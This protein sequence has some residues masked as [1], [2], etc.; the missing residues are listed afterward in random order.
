MLKAFGIWL[1]SLCVA[2]SAYA[3]EE[4]SGALHATL[5]GKVVKKDFSAPRVVEHP[6]FGWFIEL[7]SPSQT[8]VAELFE[9]LSPHEKAI[10]DDLDLKCIRIRT[11]NT[12]LRDWVREQY[13]H[14][15][16]VDG[17]IS[18]PDL[19][20]RELRAF[21]FT[22]EIEPE[23]VPKGEDIFASEFQEDWNK[24]HE[25]SYLEPRTPT[26]E[27]EEDNSLVLPEGEPEILVTMR[28]TLCLETINHDPELG[29]IDNG[30]YPL[31]CWVLE[32]DPESF[33]IVCNTPVH[34][35]FQTPESIRSSQDGHKLWLTGDFKPDWLCDHLNEIVTVQGYLWHAHT[36]H[37][38]TPVMLDTDPWFK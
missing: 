22:P 14:E 13:D 17:E 12:L 16:T 2:A 29:A 7:D 21:Y 8:I 38:H 37:H 10:Y 30:G 33:E 18:E 35:S 26:W 31:Y 28:G 20:S 36:A 6:P 27:W 23:S 15:V 32:L 9:H 5:N 4:W 3:G 19:L 24:L 11:P 34:A 1:V 25:T